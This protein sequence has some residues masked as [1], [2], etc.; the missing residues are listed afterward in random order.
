MDQSL[1][2]NSQIGYGP[3]DTDPRVPEEIRFVLSKI[4]SGCLLSNPTALDPRY[5]FAE[6]FC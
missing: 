2:S 1:P 3:L 6:T 5:P 4:L